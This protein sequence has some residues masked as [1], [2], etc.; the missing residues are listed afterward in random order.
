MNL[1]VHFKDVLSLDVLNS[2]VFASGSCDGFARVFDYRTQKQVQI[3]NCQHAD[4]NQVVFHPSR[5]QIG[6][7]TSLNKFLFYD[8]RNNQLLS[9]FQPI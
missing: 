1:A 9:E 4:C 2:N 3:F 8:L 5:N 7:A 6:L